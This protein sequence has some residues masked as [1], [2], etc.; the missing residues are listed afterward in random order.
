ME[1]GAMHEEKIY[2]VEMARAEE[3]G[4]EECCGVLMC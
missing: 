4:G 3:D 2:V 1:G